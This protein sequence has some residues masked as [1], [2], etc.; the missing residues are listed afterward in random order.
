MASQITHG[1]YLK[2]GF[3]KLLFLVLFVSNPALSEYAI[4]Y[5]DTAV[6]HSGSES[7]VSIDLDETIP[8]Y[9]DRGKAI[10]GGYLKLVGR[11]YWISIKPGEYK[12][13]PLDTGGKEYWPL[14]Q[15]KLDQV[16]RAK[17]RNGASARQP[18]PG[19]SMDRVESPV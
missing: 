15:R 10:T 16:L 19:R 2:A 1:K 4:G 9:E 7:D 13:S 3:N 18:H 5:L 6:Q 12:G 8:V 11:D 14:L 17:Q